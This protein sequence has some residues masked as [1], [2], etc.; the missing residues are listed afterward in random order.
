MAT[1]TGYT[2]THAAHNDRHDNNYYKD[3]Y[4][5]RIINTIGVLTMHTGQ[6]AM[7]FT[8]KG[9][10]KKE[11]LKNGRWQCSIKLNKVVFKQM[12]VTCKVATRS[13]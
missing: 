3:L 5:Q 12:A 6:L 9:K 8:K 4:D 1:Y 2:L 13:S 11:K 7:N 10:L